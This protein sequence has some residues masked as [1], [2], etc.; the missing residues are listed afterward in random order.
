MRRSSVTYPAGKIDSKQR[1][2]FNIVAVQ[3]SRAAKLFKACRL[4]HILGSVR[5]VEK[6]AVTHVSRRV[7]GIARSV[8]HTHGRPVLAKNLGHVPSVQLTT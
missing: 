4:E 3:C 5:L 2:D 7:Y 8:E 1:E 6:L